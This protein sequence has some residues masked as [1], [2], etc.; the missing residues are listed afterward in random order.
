MYYQLDKPFRDWLENI[1]YQDNK[2][3]KIQEWLKTL[4]K[5]VVYEAEKMLK[6]SGTRD[7]IGITE[8][9][10]VKNIA[11]AFNHFMFRLN[12]KL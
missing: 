12:K 5:L 10:S 2:D 9:E 7:Y 8:K 4:K 3:E 6:N 11:T 1:N